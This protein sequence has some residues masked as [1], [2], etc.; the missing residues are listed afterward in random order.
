MSTTEM[1]FNVGEV[2]QTHYDDPVLR[3]FFEET[4]NHLICA[5]KAAE[6]HPALR[7]NNIMVTP[8][9]IAGDFAFVLNSCV[10]LA[11]AG[12]VQVE[13]GVLVLSLKE[14]NGR[15]A[16]MV[17]NEDRNEIGQVMP[18]AVPLFLSLGAIYAVENSRRTY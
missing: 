5:R 4:A 2:S 17:L 16:M 1:N 14:K 15:P 12:K 18:E 11:G 7:P 10:E 6:E 8:Y 13:E 3:N 9:V